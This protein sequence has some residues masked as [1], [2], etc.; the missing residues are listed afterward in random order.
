M[1]YLKDFLSLNEGIAKSAIED[2]IA[3]VYPEIVND[4]GI[5]K[6]GVPPIEL[7]KDIYARLSKIPGSQGED[8][9]TS[10]AQYDADEN[11]I[12]IYYPNM[13]N[14]E[15]VIR[16]LLHEHTHTLQD[17]KKHEMY[18]KKGYKNNPYEI[19]ALKAEKN[20]KRYIKQ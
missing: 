19:A 10:K 16:S 12:F 1:K 18:R 5:G 11:K 2:V 15:D 14:E 13:L 8:S 4:L 9:S 7:W 6:Q 3:R 17:P 20:W